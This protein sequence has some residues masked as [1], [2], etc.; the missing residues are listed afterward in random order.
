MGIPLESRHTYPFPDA[1][2]P[3]KY[4]KLAKTPKANRIVDDYHPKIQ[5]MISH[6]EGKLKHADKK[7]F[8]NFS[9]QFGSDKKI[10]KKFVLHLQVSVR[11]LPEQ[12]KNAS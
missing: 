5:A 4:C 10:A 9:V 3:G 6:K 11:V 2:Q 12:R 1:N 8:E 7:S